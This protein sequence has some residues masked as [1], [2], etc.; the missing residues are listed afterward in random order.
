MRKVDIVIEI[1]EIVDKKY[2]QLYELVKIHDVS[3]SQKALE[4]AKAAISV[5]ELKQEIWKIYNEKESQS[6]ISTL[7]DDEHYLISLIAILNN[8]LLEH[9]IITPHQLHIMNQY[10]SKKIV[11]NSQRKPIK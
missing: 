4:Y 5:G 11:F 6:C 10:I 9:Q 8:E 2:R 3:D 7:V 1:I